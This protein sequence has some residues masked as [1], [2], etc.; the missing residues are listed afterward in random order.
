M[1]DWLAA[2]M[3][4]S[5]LHDV[6][7]HLSWHAR[8]MV[9]SWGVLVPLGIFI[10]RYFKIAPGQNWP[11]T[12]DHH[13]W[14]N[15]HRICQYSAC[16]LMVVGLWF[17]R[18]APPLT[19]I[20]GPHQFLGWTV[21]ALAMVQLT[22]GLLRGTKGGPTEPAPDGSLH[23]DHYDMTPRRLVFEYAHKGAGYLALLLSIAT[24]LSGL[25]Q[26]NA[27]NWMWLSLALWWG[28]LGIVSLVLQSRGMAVDTYQAIWGPDPTLPGNR[29]KPIGLGVH[30][31]SPNG[32]RARGTDS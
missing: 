14:W 7:W 27:P 29:R 15:T 9:V 5:R 18:S 20:P 1:L 10:A 31:I 13:F 16:V 21:L 11:E 19:T 17:I 24:I 8:F 23:G 28:G 12:L 4:T 6:G 32:Q 25:W 22:G 26:A 3:D 2:P 30:R